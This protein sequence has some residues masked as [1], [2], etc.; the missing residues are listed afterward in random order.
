[1]VEEVQTCNGCLALGAEA[2]CMGTTGA[3]QEQRLARRNARTRPDYARCPYPPRRMVMADKL[4]V[5]SGVL[6]HRGLRQIYAYPVINQ[7]A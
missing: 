3:D 7:G 2:G 6:R 4:E 1:M 5:G